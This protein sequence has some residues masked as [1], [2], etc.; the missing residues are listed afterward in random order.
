MGM[1]TSRSHRSRTRRRRPRALGA[2]DDRGGH[3]VVDLDVVL[4]RLA[5]QAR[6]SRRRPPSAPRARARCS[7]PW[8][9][10][11]GATRPRPP[12]PPHR[13]AGP[14]AGTAGRH[15]ARRR[16]PTVR[17]IAPTLCGSSMPSRTTT[18]AGPPRRP[19]STRASTSRS[20][21]VTSA[22]TPWW[23]AA[24]GRSLDLRRVHDVHRHAALDAPART[25]SASRGL[26]AG[27][28]GL[29]PARPP[30]A[31]SPASPFGP[32]RSRDTRPASSAD[33][34]GLTP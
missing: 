21:R 26:S 23:T 27:Q 20:R 31:C 32:I 5:R 28:D 17:R 22:T 24:A 1:R 29:Q 2:D 18:R 3:R 15:H 11:R 19:Q 4:G 30:A 7:R 13:P 16:R 10:A 12:S 6:R 9:R 25:S 33:C 8:P 34:T 14:R